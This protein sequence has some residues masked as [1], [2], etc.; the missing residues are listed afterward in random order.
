MTNVKSLI[1][2]FSCA[3]DCLAARCAIWCVLEFLIDCLDARCAIW[4]VL[5]FLIDC[6]AASCAIWC[7]LEFLI[8]CA[9]VVPLYHFLPFCLPDDMTLGIF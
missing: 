9:N 4:C 1:K 7:V 5:E 8:V 6:L 2:H 3:I